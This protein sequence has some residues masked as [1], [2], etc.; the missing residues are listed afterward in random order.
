M[1]A[2]LHSSAERACDIAI[3][4]SD[5]AFASRIDYTDAYVLPTTSTT[6]TAS[7]DVTPLPTAALVSPW[8][9]VGPS[10]G[11]AHPS[12]SL[13]AVAT[14]AGT[15][16]SPAV[17]TVPLAWRCPSCGTLEVEQLYWRR[18][19][20]SKA[21]T[22]GGAPAAADVR[23]ALAHSMRLKALS[24]ALQAKL[25]QHRRRSERREEMRWRSL[26]ISTRC[27]RCFLC[28]RCGGHG[29]LPSSETATVSDVSTSKSA[30]ASL[31][32]SLNAATLL[33][34]MQSVS[35]LDI[36]L[37]S[38][39]QYYTVCACCQWHSYRAFPT[40]EQ[41]LAYLNAV[42]GDEKAEALREHRAAQRSVNTA[43][44]AGLTGLLGAKPDLEDD[45]S[46]QQQ[47]PTIS[48][49]AWD[50]F[51]H[52]RSL[53]I[54]NQN[55]SPPSHS[56][57]PQQQSVE[58]EQQL[59]NKI[60]TDTIMHLHPALALEQLQNQERQ[61][62]EAARAVS[63]LQGMSQV[64][65]QT[66][67]VVDLA[68]EAAAQLQA[69]RE[70]EE[71]DMTPLSKLPLG[72]RLTTSASITARSVKED[73]EVDLIAR[74]QQ[75]YLGLPVE[76]VD[77]RDQTMRAWMQR[78]QPAAVVAQERKA[79]AAAA[80]TA[81]SAATASPA[82]LPVRS[83]QVEM[84]LFPSEAATS[85]SA[86]APPPSATPAKVFEEPSPEVYTPPVPSDTATDRTTTAGTAPPAAAAMTSTSALMHTPTSAYLHSVLL[87]EQDRPLGLPAYYIPRVRKELLSAL[88]WRLPQ[89]SAAG[90]SSATKQ[91][92][93]C[94]RLVLLDRSALLDDEVR[95]VCQHWV[96]QRTAQVERHKRKHRSDLEQQNSAGSTPAVGM[97][98]NHRDGGF[99]SDGGD[100]EDEDS[101]GA[102]EHPKDGA[103][104]DSMHA[105]TSRHPQPQQRLRQKALSV[106]PVPLFLDGT[107]FAAVSCLPFLEY[108]RNGGSSARPC[109]RQLRLVNLRMMHDIYLTKLEVARTV[110]APTCSIDAQH[111]RPQ[112]SPSSDSTPCV[113]VH[114]SSPSV[115]AV[116]LPLALAPQCS[117]V[118]RAAA[119]AAVLKGSDGACATEAGPLP[120]HVPPSLLTM[121][122]TTP[123]IRLQELHITLC[124]TSA[125]QACMPS[126]S[127]MLAPLHC[128]E[129]LVE[130]ATALSGVDHARPQY[131]SV[132]YGLTVTFNSC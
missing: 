82:A 68:R 92:C 96:D 101:D 59:S 32:P 57:P 19:R 64:A 60:A 110:L 72:Y 117:P 7:T 34:S 15:T 3:H 86:T 99:D 9:L 91:V 90:Q 31:S 18:P 54:H 74:T 132:R 67:R 123:P 108:V 80:G 116:K 6:E 70:E 24:P 36:R 106:L 76:T 37:T 81:T 126:S 98:C 61:R 52:L 75:C 78:Y 66:M 128:V 65:P 129:L 94:T 28:P 38:D 40:M 46:L 87:R 4:L 20:R 22:T 33:S 112:S 115:P 17:E 119:V 97:Q 13:P 48:Q 39:M 121:G 14:A 47:Q 83:K 131:H 27:R 100:E 93:P 79:A 56:P 125:A 42:M 111:A 105:T 29:S 89:A 45:V 21:P 69:A 95:Q 113:T 130:V 43:L 120:P 2:V 62:R 5:T 53:H 25:E 77:T 118:E 58:G 1:M 114:L 51:R 44:R 55:V 73:V 85:D 63:L 50:A 102:I 30:A 88:V 122:N 41:L 10:A 84:A 103:S 49:A 23:A 107:D 104:Q 127:P 12:S 16:I 26:Y 109:E 35:S 11:D 8:L 124:E 71:H